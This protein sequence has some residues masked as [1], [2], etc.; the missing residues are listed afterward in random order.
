MARQ[1]IAPTGTR[2][3]YPTQVELRLALLREGDLAGAGDRDL[4]P[5]C[6]HKDRVFSQYGVTIP[7]PL[8]PALPQRS[9]RQRAVPL[10]SSPSTPKAV[11]TEQR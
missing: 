7:A 8:P 11:W 2:L 3:E 5:A 6:L 1:P 9:S 4:V 10:G